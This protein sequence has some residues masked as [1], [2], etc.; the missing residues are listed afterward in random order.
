MVAKVFFLLM[1]MLSKSKCFDFMNSQIFFGTCCYN[2]KGAI[3]I[4]SMAPYNI[5]YCNLYW[6]NN[7]HFVVNLN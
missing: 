6:I 5:G 7:H 1:T 2:K 3:E 4:V